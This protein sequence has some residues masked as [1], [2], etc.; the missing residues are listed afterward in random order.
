MYLPNLEIQ[1]CQVFKAPVLLH[2]FR[3]TTTH[4][5][6]IELREG[7]KGTKKLRNV[8]WTI[9]FMKLKKK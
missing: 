7:A 2:D 1:M 9:R 4:T 8:T 5:R 3:S 6:E